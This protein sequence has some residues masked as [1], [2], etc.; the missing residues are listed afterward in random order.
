MSMAEKK[1]E[2]CNK[3]VWLKQ[4]IAP[5]VILKVAIVALLFLL[6]IGTYIIKCKSGMQS[7]IPAAFE[8]LL[9]G[10]CQNVDLSTV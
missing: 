10:E 2:P 4:A 1:S 5:V 6:S 8:L 3:R 7:T 9:I